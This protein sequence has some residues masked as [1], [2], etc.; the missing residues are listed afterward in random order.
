MSETIPSFNQ[1]CSQ[2]VE[3]FLQTVVIIDNEAEIHDG[4]VPESKKASRRSEAPSAKPDK[5]MG[6]GTTHGGGN[7]RNVPV[8]NGNSHILKLNKVANAFAKKNLTCGI[9]IPSD[10]DPPD[11]EE[12]IST[13]VNA[14]LHTDAC[15]LDWYLRDNDAGQAIEVIKRV[16][17]K[18]TEAGGQLRL[19]LV[20]TA[21]PDLEEA[22]NMLAKELCDANPVDDAEV[23]T[24]SATNL[25]IVFLN[26]PTTTGRLEN[27]TQ[28]VEWEDLPERVVKEFTELSK[29]LIRAYALNSIANI[30]R[31]THRILAQ[32]NPCLDAAYVADR[33]TKP[34][35]TDGDKL[36]KEIFLSELSLSIETDGDILKPLSEEGCNLW[37]E[38]A[39]LNK[40]VRDIPNAQIKILNEEKIE[41]VCG[42]QREK[43]IREGFSKVTSSHKQYFVSKS[44]FESDDIWLSSMEKMA[45]LA[46]VAYHNGQTAPRPPITPPQLSLGTIILST[47]NEMMFCL[48][49]SC[50]AVRL[51]EDQGF[52]FLN[53]VQ[54]ENKFNFVLPVGNELKKYRLP[55]KMEREVRTLKFTPDPSFNV[56]LAITDIDQK[57]K[58]K[59]KENV[60]LFWVAELRE[61]VAVQSAQDFLKPL[62]RLGLNSLEWL[63][64][65]VGFL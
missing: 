45:I 60:N 8:N 28:K 41:S 30:R 11:D 33:A 17:V 39:T 46:T 4:G 57:W 13:A 34:D 2:A 12:L 29:G 22:S 37:L 52:L 49:P 20:Y 43:F 6:A 61:M 16:W 14:V 54:D 38:N 42:N 56:V 32:F 27:P 40:V 48:Q 26:K 53:L 47:K 7:T 31:D 51:K 3:K 1:L 62:S 64:E 36:I 44:F 63:R 35:P 10:L 5:D 55:K 65:D 24:L 9:Y 50:D 58:F 19:I 25:R 59:D 18:D 15:V 23:P 21:E